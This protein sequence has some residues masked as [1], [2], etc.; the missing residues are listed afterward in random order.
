[1]VAPHPDLHDRIKSAMN[2]LAATANVPLALT[3]RAAEPRALG[4][5]DDVIIP[6]DE[7]PLGTAP[8][9]IR[10]TAAHVSRPLRGT[11]RVIVVLVDFP[12]KQMTET[13]KH[14]EDL[15]FSLGTLG[16]KSVPEY[17]REVTHSLIDIQGDV[18]GPI[19]L[20]QTIKTYANGA[21]GTGPAL[22][23]ARTWRATP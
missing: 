20:P 17:Y 23:N 13:R 7:F 8:S 12:D 14:F 5:N 6:P 15:F 21:A 3:L 18:V 10:A 16:T 19:R 11:V 22:P 1:M 4:F 2:S 9:V